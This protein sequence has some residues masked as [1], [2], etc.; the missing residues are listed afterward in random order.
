M[1]NYFYPNEKITPSNDWKRMFDGYLWP[2]KV[3]ASED[4]IA[5]I[6][7]QNQFC[8][9]IWGHKVNPLKF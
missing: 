6:S 2:A 7:L 5:A 8:F 3:L 1:G 9:L 4:K